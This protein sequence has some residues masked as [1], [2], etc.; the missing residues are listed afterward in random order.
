MWLKQSTAVTIR[1]GPALDKTDGVTEETGLSPTV[2]VSKA[3]AAFAAR[4]SASAISHDSNGW[5]AVPLDTTDTGTVGPLIVKFDSAADHLP[6]WREFLVVPAN[7][8][9]SV[10]GGTDN[11]QV[12]TVQWLGTACATP[13]VAGVPEVD[14]THWNGTAVG[15]PDTAGYPKVTIKD[16]TGTGELDTNAGKVALTDASVDTIWDELLTTSAHNTD[17]S[18][19]Q[20]LRRASAIATDGVV[21]DAAA[22]TTSFVVGG[23][24]TVNDFFNDQ[25]LVFTTGALAG[26]SKPVLDYDG[27]TKTITLSE[28][29]TSAPANGVEFVLVPVH[30]HPVSQI[31][32]GVWDEALAGH[33]GAGSAGEALTDAAAGGG[34]DAAGVRAAVGLASANLDTQLSGVQNDTNDIQTRLPAALVGGRMDADVG[35]MQAN[36]LT[37]TAIA[38]DAITDAK[39][40]SDVTIASV[41]G[42]VGSVA[43]GGITASSIATGAIDADSL[44]ADAVDEI[45]DEVADGAITARQVLK[46]VLAWIGGLTSGGGT[47]SIQF[48][49]QDDTTNAI[50]MTTDADGDRS[51]VTFDL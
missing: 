42:A 31:A 30:V 21:N 25:V 26:Q 51:A 38:A 14:P 3:H 40:A 36:V 10:V 13:S 27:A 17:T 19:G 48:K 35:A 4:N 22:T 33:A 24:I 18:A 44:A 20:R 49:R 9:D 45:W 37:A 47:T 43:A 15:T 23:T 28:A 34:L 12:D 6:V 5:Y 46:A 16:G 8:Y 1:L 29:L 11:L 39:V 32:D 50:S 2:E 7:V 41:T